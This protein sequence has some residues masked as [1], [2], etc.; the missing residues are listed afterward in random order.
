MTEQNRTAQHPLWARVLAG[1]LLALCLLYIGNPSGG[2]AEVLLD[3]VPVV[4]N[5]DEG[6]A[7]YLALMALRYL[8]V[9]VPGLSGRRE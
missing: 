3:N 7:A 5:L 1:L 8:G 9:R 4:G 6:V 2:V